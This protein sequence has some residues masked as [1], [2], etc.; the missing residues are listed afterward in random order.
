MKKK[1]RNWRGA[2]IVLLHLW[3][4]SLSRL[5]ATSHRLFFFVFFFFVFARCFALFFYCLRRNNNN[6]SGN[7]QRAMTKTKALFCYFYCIKIFSSPSPPPPPSIES[8]S[9]HFVRRYSSCTFGCA[10]RYARSILSSMRAINLF[11]RRKKTCASRETIFSVPSRT[12]PLP[13]RAAEC[14]LFADFI[15]CIFCGMSFQ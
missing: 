4:Q 13:I 1:K 3:P 5:V 15:H 8:R 2:F 14:H 11:E 12:T 10:V 6:T 7:G 9:K